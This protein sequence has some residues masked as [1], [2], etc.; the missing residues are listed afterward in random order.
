MK[1]IF[2]LLFVATFSF[3]SCEKD[4]ICDPNTPTTPRLIISFYSV[5]EPSTLKPV[6]KLFL[7]GDGMTTGILYTN[8]STIQVP[9]QT[10]LDSTQYSFMLNYGN[11]DP[12]TIY[13]DILQFNYSRENIY[14]SRACG[15][16]TIFSLNNELGLPDPFV[17]N[18]DPDKI[19]GNWI[20]YITVKNFNVNSENETQ[21]N[22]Y[23]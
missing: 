15:F 4:D 6:S 18:N 9:L 11:S 16:K 13:T 7:L 2:L 5:V 21:I 12:E 23:Y 8:S 14:V 19:E 17:L 3:S 20:K 22:I 1:K 10:T